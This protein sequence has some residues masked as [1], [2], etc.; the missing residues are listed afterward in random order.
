M[1][2]TLRCHQCGEVI[3]T[4]EP[5]FVIVDGQPQERSRLAGPSAAEFALEPAAEPADEPA[6]E[7]A[8]E[9]ATEP[10]VEPVGIC[11]HRKCFEQRHADPTAS[12]ESSA[13]GGAALT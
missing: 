9:P 13:L 12:A 11:Y 10:A 2:D 1:S 8:A 4:Y 3:G 5:Y 7:P 6:A